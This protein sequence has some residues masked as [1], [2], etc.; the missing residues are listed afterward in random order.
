[1]LK[2]SGLVNF[3]LFSITYAA[4]LGVMRDYL[5]TPKFGRVTEFV[6]FYEH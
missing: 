3:L 6:V 1:M 4:G 2:I 5:V